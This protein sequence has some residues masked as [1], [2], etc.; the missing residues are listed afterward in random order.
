MY[1]RFKNELLNRETFF[2]NVEDIKNWHEKFSSAPTASKTLIMG[3][4]GQ[5]YVW[6]LRL[7]II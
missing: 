1:R 5:P 3:S 2:L 6:T 7:D 4:T